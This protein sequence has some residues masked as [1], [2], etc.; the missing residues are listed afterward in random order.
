MK[1]ETSRVSLNSFNTRAIIVTATFAW[2]SSVNAATANISATVTIVPPVSMAEPSDMRFSGF[3]AGETRGTI[4]LLVPPALPN[5]APTSA[6]PTKTGSRLPTGGVR[7]VG[8][9]NCSARLNCGVG[10]FQIRGPSSNSFS[11]VSTQP[12]TTLTS[13]DNTMTLHSIALR[14]GAGGSAGAVSGPGTLDSAGNGTIMIGGV[15]NVAAGQAV[16]AYTGSLTVS[17]D[18]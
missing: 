8:G 11:G 15:L 9:R 13:G 18:Y 12:T 16:G 3:V 4:K 7:L 1:S 5:V 17:V 10:A 14:Y 2:A 6:T